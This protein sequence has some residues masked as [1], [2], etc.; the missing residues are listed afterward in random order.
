[1]AKR[2]RLFAFSFH[3]NGFM[4]YTSFERDCPKPLVLRLLLN[5]KTGWLDREDE[6]PKL[7]P[8]EAGALMCDRSHRN[9]WSARAFR[10]LAIERVDLRRCFEVA[11]FNVAGPDHAA[12]GQHVQD[13]SHLPASCALFP[14]IK[15]R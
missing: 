14:H 1:M 6:V 13:G 9:G 4:R 15:K 11:G 5:L 7:C 10:F 3:Q 8:L 12:C 2:G